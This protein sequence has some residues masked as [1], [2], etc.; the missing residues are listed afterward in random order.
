MTIKKFDH[1]SI[2][3]LPEP[4]RVQMPIARRRQ[5]AL[6]KFGPCVEVTTKVLP[7]PESRS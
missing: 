2:D 4:A 3:L 6:T 1:S 7:G 5:E